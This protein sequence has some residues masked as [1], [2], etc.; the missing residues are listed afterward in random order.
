M[1]S[2]IAAHS[3]PCASSCLSSSRTS[4][5]PQKETLYPL[6]VTRHF[7]S[8]PS[9]QP[10]AATGLLS[11]LQI[12]LLWT[13]HTHRVIQDAA[14]C[15]WLLS[16]S[17]V[18]SRLEDITHSGEVLELTYGRPSL[19]FPEVRTLPMSLGLQADHCRARLPKHRM[20]VWSGHR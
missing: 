7:L 8:T 10:L 4:S 14:F 3:Q 9:L 16:P 1:I 12:C 11:V 18:S 17:I 20:S 13:F 2:G 15:V 5:S 6:T 19:N